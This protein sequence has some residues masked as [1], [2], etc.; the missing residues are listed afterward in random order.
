MLS[1]SIATFAEAR[2]R[3][4]GTSLAKLDEVPDLAEVGHTVGL[5]KKLADSGY[6]F[7]GDLG[8]ELYAGIFLLGYV[9]PYQGEAS[10]N[11]WVEDANTLW[12]S[13]T[14]KEGDRQ[15]EI[16]DVAGSLVK[17]KLKSVVIDE[18]ADTR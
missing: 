6:E 3:F 4:A 10:S 16:R 7:T 12:G 2:L 8:A 15:R 9:I 5:V 17:E 14:S 18:R 11:K 13:W 1:N